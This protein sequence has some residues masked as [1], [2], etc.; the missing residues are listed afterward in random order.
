MGV[1]Y[2]QFDQTFKWDVNTIRRYRFYIFKRK[3]KRNF[4]QEYLK[5]SNC[6]QIKKGITDT[7]NKCTKN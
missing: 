1:H 2:T 7:L 3:C 5:I 6:F 4:K